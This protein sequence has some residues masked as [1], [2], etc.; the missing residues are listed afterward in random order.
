M[1]DA[2]GGHFGFFIQLRLKQF[3]KYFLLISCGEQEKPSRNL[4]NN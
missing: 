2:V 3:V 4:A 1:H